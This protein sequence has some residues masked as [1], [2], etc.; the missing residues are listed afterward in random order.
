MILL[1]KIDE[2]AKIMKSKRTILIKK[3]KKL[4]TEDKNNNNNTK[5][6]RQK[7]NKFLLEDTF[8]KL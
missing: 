2:T 5:D 8:K 4:K 6:K 1:F 7:K 3:T